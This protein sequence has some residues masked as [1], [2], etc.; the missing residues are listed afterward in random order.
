MQG[1]STQPAAQSGPHPVPPQQT[2]A[3]TESGLDGVRRR[4]VLQTPGITTDTMAGFATNNQIS[5][6]RDRLVAER[7]IPAL[8][9]VTADTFMLAGEEQ[10]LTGDSVL[11]RVNAAA[12][13]GDVWPGERVDP[14]AAVP[15]AQKSILKAAAFKEV[16]ESL[17]E[18][19]GLV[20]NMLDRQY[21]SKL[22]YQ[23]VRD[24]V[25]N[26]LPG[27]VRGGLPTWS[28]VVD[29]RK[30]QTNVASWLNPVQAPADFAKREDCLHVPDVDDIP[31]DFVSAGSERRS[32]RS[33]VQ[34]T[35]VL[36]SGENYARHDYNSGVAIAR[37][38]Y[39]EN[40]SFCQH[41]GFV[42]EDG[43][44]ELLSRSLV[45]T[46]QLTLPS[47]I[48]K[49]PSAFEGPDLYIKVMF[50]GRQFGL[51]RHNA[52]TCGGISIVQPGMELEWSSDFNVTTL[53]E[54]KGGD[55][56]AHLRRWVDLTV[57]VKYLRRKWLQV[58]LVDEA[59]PRQY[60]V[61]LFLGAD[62]KAHWAFFDC[63]GTHDAMFC[64][65]CKCQREQRWTLFKLEK[66]AARVSH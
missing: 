64:H 25:G 13:A 32:M 14:E 28:A 8:Q 42:S 33:Q 50:D 9:A 57:A 61:Q 54:W 45:R 35:V 56:A 21:I 36:D 65:R 60:K 29:E 6:L 58:K 4:L 51:K 17:G 63:G 16:G 3:S 5:A 15:A 66:P 22:Q 49:Y 48:A 11:W 41:L 2:P 1:S 47:W 18:C 10:R 12:F 46:L 62:M 20:V 53:A 30:R 31:S 38:A 39:I 43:K 59:N 34:S 52:F 23:A 40:V 27:A 7:V 19:V 44:E 37:P 24:V 26:A 55:D